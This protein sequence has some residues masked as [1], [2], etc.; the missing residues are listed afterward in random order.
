M[1]E[2][3]RFASTR[4]DD[5]TFTALARR[6]TRLGL[7]P[8]DVIERYIVRGITQDV[9]V[10]DGNPGGNVSPYLRTYAELQKQ[11]ERNQV[12]TML[13]QLARNHLERGDEQT[14]DTL[15]DLCDSNSVTIEEI[16][17]RAQVIGDVPLAYDDGRGLVS[18]MIWLRQVVPPG[19]ELLYTSI[20]A[21]GEKSGFTEYIL[22]A[23]KKK[24]KMV[25]QHR[26]MPWVWVQPKP[27]DVPMLEERERIGEG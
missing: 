20:M 18:A 3:K 8:A 9:E 11:R 16:T 6:A 5:N 7:H 1:A 24:L 12:I 17:E 13:I 25:S 2:R 4:L 21:Q 15:R 14:A 10:E 23:A 26:G 19:T 22:R 27:E